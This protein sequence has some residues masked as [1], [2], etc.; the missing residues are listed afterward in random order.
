MIKK[1]IKFSSGFLPD[2]LKNK[3]KFLWIKFKT[4]R[5]IKNHT[6]ELNRLNIKA[7]SKEP[8]KVV[9]LVIHHSIW[10]FE[11]VFQKMIDDDFFAPEI[12]ICPYIIYG[13]EQMQK[14][15]DSGFDF[16]KRKGFPVKKALRNDGGWV[17]IQSLNPDIVFFTNPYPLTL[18]KY[19]YEPLKNYLSC[20]LP[21]YF[22]ATNHAGATRDIYSSLFLGNVWKVFWPHDYH[23]ENHKKFNFN[24]ASNGVVSGYPSME[25]LVYKKEISENPWKPQ[26]NKEKRIIIAPHHTIKQSDEYSLSSFIELSDFFIELALKY[27]DS[28]QW[29]FKPHPM[30]KPN[31]INH[32]DWG[33][34]KTEKYYSFWDNNDFTQLD[35][36]DYIS[37]F[38]F[39]DAIMHDSSSFICEYVFTGKPGLYLMDKEKS[40]K[41]VND[42]GQM[43]LS[44]YQVDKSKS[45]ID[46]FVQ[47][48]ISEINL[49][50]KNEN[51]KEYISDYYKD[52]KPS[53]LIVQEIKNEIIR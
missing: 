9:F 49:K 32:P 1:I 16:F 11:Q 41:I 13:D 17:K 22:M 24:N 53:D 30:L 45:V 23:L 4:K 12:L 21:Y 38:H 40:E 52:N 15:M 14:D 2:A 37:L 31:L 3:V 39:S 29:S 19:F 10:K 51:I 27:K 43:F 18:S 50:E 28:V 26:K 25:P 46:Q 8:I 36:G 35:E 48:I 42:F 7:K 34:A 44:T 33:R 5:I 47:G 6:R 20:Y